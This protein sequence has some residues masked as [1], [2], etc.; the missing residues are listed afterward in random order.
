M[1]QELSKPLS[2]HRRA[3]TAAHPPIKGAGA[4]AVP[5][6]ALK[7]AASNRPPVVGRVCVPV[8]SQLEGWIAR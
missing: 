5:M 1:T 3:N 7:P 6:P 8:L 2:Q 4:R